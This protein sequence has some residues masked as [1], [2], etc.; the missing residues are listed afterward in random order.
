MNVYFVNPTYVKPEGWKP[1]LTYLKVKAAYSFIPKGDIPESLYSIIKPYLKASYSNQNMKTFADN[2][3][4]WLKAHFEKHINLITNDFDDLDGITNEIRQKYSSQSAFNNIKY[5]DENNCL[6]LLN[7]KSDFDEEGEISY[8]KFYVDGLQDRNL[9]THITRYCLNIL[10]KKYGHNQYQE[11]S[12]F[13]TFGEYF[14]TTYRFVPRYQRWKRYMLKQINGELIGFMSC[15]NK[16][17]MELAPYDFPLIDDNWKKRYTLLR[18][19]EGEERYKQLLIDAKEAWNR[20][21]EMQRYDYN[22]GDNWQ[23]EVDEMN[24]AFW[25]E[26]GEA[27]S[28]CESWP[29]WDY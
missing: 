9:P 3:V 5:L 15:V 6:I 23:E 4:Y 11:Q 21:K 20:Y 18:T 14:H 10:H 27:G 25:R 2:C 28:N 19:E 7:L 12:A 16:G 8:P 22:E 24:R 13:I 29:G 17:I 1:L 26:C